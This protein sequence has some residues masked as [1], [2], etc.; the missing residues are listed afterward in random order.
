VKSTNNFLFDEPIIFHL[1]IGFMNKPGVVTGVM[2]ASQIQRCYASEGGENGDFLPFDH[3]S[4][5]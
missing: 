1:L 4:L 5:Y 3:H 2:A